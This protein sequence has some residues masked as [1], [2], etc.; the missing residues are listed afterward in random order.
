MMA[1]EGAGGLAVGLEAAELQLLYWKV[2]NCWSQELDLVG[3]KSRDNGVG[4][5]EVFCH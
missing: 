4:I 1:A 2:P 3:E 5:G